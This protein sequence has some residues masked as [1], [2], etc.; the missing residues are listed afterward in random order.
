[1]ITLFYTSIQL[2]LISA[3]TDG[4]GDEIGEPNSVSEEV[5]M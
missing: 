5:E 4:A 3:L 2:L 1:M